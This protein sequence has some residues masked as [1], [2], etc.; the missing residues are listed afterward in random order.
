MHLVKHKPATIR[1]NPENMDSKGFSLLELMVVLLIIALLIAIAI[2]I[3]SNVLS[4]A[5]NRTCQANLRVIDG[6][7]VKYKID[8]EGKNPISVNVLVDE[9]Y[10][11]E[12]PKCP[13]NGALYT[14]SNDGTAICNGSPQHSY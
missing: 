2:P 9:G 11:K 7:I 3:Y 8:H 10:L 6:S 12:V 5:Y 13:S 14:I 4:K 1:Q